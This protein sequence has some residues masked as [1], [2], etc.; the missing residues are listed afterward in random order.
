MFLCWN[1]IQLYPFPQWYTSA[2]R[3]STGVGCEGQNMFVDQQVVSSLCLQKCWSIYYKKYFHIPK[4]SWVIKDFGIL[5]NHMDFL[6]QHATEYQTQSDIF[7]V[8]SG[9]SLQ[10]RF[11]R[12]YMQS[13]AWLKRKSSHSRIQQQ[14]EFE[15]IDFD[16]A[17]ATFPETHKK[18]FT[19]LSTEWGNK[20]DILNFKSEKNC[21]SPTFS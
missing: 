8:L 1:Q 21:L 9:D 3:V 13:C 18:V 10:I 5:L 11:L 14:V 20:S 19:K 12:K 15:Q 6:R 4:V 2:N 16:A 17:L 7:H